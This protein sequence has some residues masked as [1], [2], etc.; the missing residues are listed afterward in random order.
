MSEHEIADFPALFYVHY[1]YKGSTPLLLSMAE[2]A[3]NFSDK[4]ENR[5]LCALFG[6]LGFE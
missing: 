2:N 3:K 4:E 1:V 5:E 6:S